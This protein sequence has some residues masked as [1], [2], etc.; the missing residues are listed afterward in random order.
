MQ[1]PTWSGTVPGIQLPGVLL[2]PRVGPDLLYTPAARGP[3][4][5]TPSLTIGEEFNDNIFLSNANKHSDF[6]TQFTP[7][8]T[9][10]M[11]QPGLR[12]TAG[13][14]FTA[15]IYAQHSEFNDAAN[16]Q[17][18]VTS[19]SYDATP[20]VTLNLTE[21]FYY[22]KN[23]NAVAPS[24]VSSG[25]QS[26]L[27]NVF[28]PALSVQATQRMTWR[29]SG[30]YSLERY[31]GPNSQDSNIYRIGPG[32]DYTVTPRL[33]VT[34]GYDFGY[35]D[36]DREP[37]ALNH[38][39]R[40]G[41]TYR[42]TPT[43][44]ATATA[45][46]SILITDRDTTVSPAVSARLTQEMSWGF[47]GVFYDRSIGT[48]G[49][50]GGPSDNQA[51]GGNIAARTLLRGLTIDFSPRYTMSSTESA[52]RSQSDIK[53]LTLNLSARYQIARYIA[54]VGSYT[55]LQ[56]RGS[57]NAALANGNTALSDVDQNRVNLGLQFGYP[58]NFD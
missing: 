1:D 44:T 7:G 4:T 18:L 5:V 6:I 31:S 29:L 11:Q 28:A 50:F 54:I 58:I 43:L 32:V 56:Q 41:G 34:T 25:R 9:L 48:T 40:F 33:T 27:S 21:T 53:T 17:N 45:G 14:N 55:F 36:I 20:G 24:S 15:E 22:S 23:S 46:P 35:L 37:T 52:A 49:G 38:T 3:L 57:G 42:I 8:V 12:L 10:Q 30:A 26:S 13:Y 16:R 47:M 19:V 51:F 2:P 39:L